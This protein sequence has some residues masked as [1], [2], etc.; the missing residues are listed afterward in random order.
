VEKNRRHGGRFDD[1]SSGCRRAD[2]AVDRRGHRGVGCRDA[3]VGGGVGWG[4]VDAQQGH[5]NGDLRFRPLQVHPSASDLGATTGLTPAPEG[6]CE[7]DDEDAVAA[8]LELGSELELERELEG[9]DA[10]FVRR[11]DVPPFSNAR[12]GRRKELGG[13]ILA[14]PARC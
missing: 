5:C 1:R 10:D 12:C 3:V 2:R 8:G 11:K 14:A 4:I 7:E 6:W 9:V 13:G